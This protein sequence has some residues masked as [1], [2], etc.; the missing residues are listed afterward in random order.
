MCLIVQR[1]PNKGG[2]HFSALDGTAYVAFVESRTGGCCQQ[3]QAVI[4]K[5]RYF[6]ESAKAYREYTTTDGRCFYGPKGEATKEAYRF[7]QEYAYMV[8]TRG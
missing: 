8:Q 4:I 6:S 7:I 2:I 1:K 5:Q 3:Y